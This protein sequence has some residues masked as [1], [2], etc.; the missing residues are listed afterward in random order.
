MP[1]SFYGSPFD[2]GMGCFEFFGEHIDSLSDNFHVLDKAIIDNRIRRRFR[3][4]IF[5]TTF[6]NRLDCIQNVLNSF[7][8]SNWLSHK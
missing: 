7:S 4:S 8:I 2:F 3:C 6:F 1:H 5:E